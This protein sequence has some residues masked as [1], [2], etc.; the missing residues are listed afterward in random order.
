[1]ATLGRSSLVVCALTLACN[2]QNPARPAGTA[3]PSSATAAPATASTETATSGAKLPIPARPSD[4]TP[5]PITHPCVVSAAQYEKAID[6]GKTDCKTDA[7]CGCYQGGVGRKSGCGGVLNQQ[8]LVPLSRIAKEFH[9]RG[10]KHTQQCAAWACQ[11]KCD[12]GHC[13]R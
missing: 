5:D 11:P 10:C 7:D 3:A 4:P 1:M 13:R 12:Q 2:T 8:S 6:E 9:D